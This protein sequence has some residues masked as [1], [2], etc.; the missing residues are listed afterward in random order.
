M[1]VKGSTAGILPPMLHSSAKIHK[2]N[3]FG[4]NY[5]GKFSM[6]EKSGLMAASQGSR[7]HLQA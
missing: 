1:M 7:R 6:R 2:I 3:D 4:K 5:H